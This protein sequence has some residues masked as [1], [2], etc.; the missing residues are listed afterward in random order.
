MNDRPSPDRVFRDLELAHAKAAELN[1]EPVDFGYTG[2]HVGV[3]APD[4]YWVVNTK[5]LTAEDLDIE[6][7]VYEAS[8]LRGVQDA[9]SDDDYWREVDGV[10]FDF[11]EL[12]RSYPDT[13]LLVVFRTTSRPDCRFGYRQSLWPTPHRTP[14]QF[15]HYWSVEFVEFL[16]TDR[17]ARHVRS[18]PCA[19]GKI[20]WL[21]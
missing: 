21:N 3:G 6:A 15:L 20:N 8:I 10:S 16:G 12:E 1:R 18:G 19:K 13:Q 7:T 5:L 11:V 14:G 2:W 9:T 17:R 4:E